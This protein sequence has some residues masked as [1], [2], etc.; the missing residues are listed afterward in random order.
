[1]HLDARGIISIV[2]IVIY[3][4]IL[5]AGI[6]L[7]VRNG[8]ARKAGWISL[9]VLS[10]IRII[11]A[12][13]HILSEE[14]P[15]NVTD[16][17][18]YGI[19]ESAGTSPLLIATVGF[20]RTTTQF[21]LDG[22]TLVIKGLRLAG[23]A[24]LV[25]LILAIIGGSEIGNA[26]TQSALNTGTNLR[27]SGAIIFAVVYGVTVLLTAYCWANKSVILKY[28]QRLLTG[29]IITLPFIFVRVLYGVLSSFAPSPFAIVDGQ[30]VPTAP[31]NSGL[32]KFS[33]TSSEWAIYLIMSVLAEY[34]SVFIY[35][36]FGIITPL[37]KDAVD[38]ENAMARST[39]SSGQTLN[40]APQYGYQ[41]PPQAKAYATQ[42]PGGYDG[43]R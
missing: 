14:N 40:P 30:L 1:M 41:Y 23:L 20:L 18:I 27:H 17:I 29:I 3:V 12:V 21:G 33:S 43:Y 31:S 2:V 36:V 11:G 24:S 35:T 42:Q 4:P 8:F 7:S 39:N 37:S 22:T 10:I 34:I 13:T 25:G 9:V 5:V 28:R 26:T 16:R 19:M 38:Y 15:T 32:A 6:F